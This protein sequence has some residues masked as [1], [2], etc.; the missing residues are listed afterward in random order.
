MKVLFLQSKLDNPI[1]KDGLLHREEQLVRALIKGVP[2]CGDE[3]ESISPPGTPQ[4]LGADVLAFVGLK[5]Q[6]WFDWC[7]ANGQS[8]MYLDKGYYHREFEERKNIIL[9]RVTVGGQQPSEY[10][11]RAKHD[12]E[13][14]LSL[15]REMAPWRKSR[16]DSPVIIGNSTEKYHDFFDL[17]PPGEWAEQVVA[18]LKRYTDRPIWYRPKPS[19]RGKRAIP[20]TKYCS[21]EP[22]AKLFPGAHGVVTHGSYI[23]VDGLLNGV[24]G[25]ILG[26]GVTRSI[27]ST[28]LSEI[29]NPRLASDEERL[30]LLA[31]LAWCQYHLE[32]WADGSAWRHVKELFL[33]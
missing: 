14:W 24:P 22:L 23:C 11:A 21:T 20:G 13:R 33:S 9:W 15:G 28:S 2:K 32:E 30:Q 25:I 12:P 3:F 18:E 5:R 19:W 7:A 1:R 6:K 8:F 27:S 31:N 26:D 17:P 16:P 10:L 4:D 29:E